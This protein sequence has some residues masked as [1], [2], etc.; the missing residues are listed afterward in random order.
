MKRTMR[1][2]L[3]TL[4]GKTHEK[5]SPEFSLDPTAKPISPKIG[6]RTSFM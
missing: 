5:A 1:V 2:V 6:G 3:P 4:E